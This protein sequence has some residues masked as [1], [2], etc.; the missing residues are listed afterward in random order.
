MLVFDDEGETG[1]HEEL[2]NAL[3]EKGQFVLREKRVITDQQGRVK[4]FIVAEEREDAL[5]C[6]DKFFRGEVLSAKTKIYLLVSVNR[7]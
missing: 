4:A 1:L 5:H 6:F 7:S 3:D 2:E